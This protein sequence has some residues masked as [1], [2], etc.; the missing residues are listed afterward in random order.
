MADNAKELKDQV[1]MLRL[2]PMEDSQDEKVESLWRQLMVYKSFAD[3]DLSEARGRR[4][5]AEAERERAEMDS[6]RAT[7]A[8]CDR[9]RAESE[10]AQQ[11]AADAKQEAIR[12]RK[13]AEAELG[14]AKETRAQSEKERDQ[15]L[16]EAQKG[17]QDIIDQARVAAEQE[18]T[19]LRRQALKEV[20]T[21]M[22]RIENM[23]AAVNEEMETQR[24]LTN[25]AKLKSSYTAM[26]ADGAQ[27]GA[28]DAAAEPAE[29]PS[30]AS[31]D[32]Q[33]AS[34]V[35]DNGAEFAVAT[36]KPKRVTPKA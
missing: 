10:A 21:V 4:A 7:K 11:E 26:L 20:R 1:D 30:P 25:V 5:Q 23:R 3:G 28:E 22:T 16:A 13:E 34:S 27:D 36:S 12:A 29:D 14:R 33:T 32:G 2:L 31:S 8:L 15:I 17:T 6:L 24:I 35:G 18:T 9:M 19:G